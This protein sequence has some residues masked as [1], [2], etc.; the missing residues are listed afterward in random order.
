MAQGTRRKA[1]GKNNQ[2]KPI[3]SFPYAL[4]LMPSTSW[5]GKAI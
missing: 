5:D 4:R 3:L 2:K 1:Q